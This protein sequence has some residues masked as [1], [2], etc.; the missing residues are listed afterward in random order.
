VTPWVTRRGGA[1]L[2]VVLWKLFVFLSMSA[3]T[4]GLLLKTPSCSCWLEEVGTLWSMNE[5]TRLAES[6]SKLCDS[7]D[8]GSLDRNSVS[9]MI[10]MRMFLGTASSRVSEA[11]TNS[12]NAL[13]AAQTAGED[14]SLP[15]CLFFSTAL[16]IETVNMQYIAGLCFVWMSG[17][18]AIMM[19]TL[20]I[21][22]D[23]VKIL[24][25]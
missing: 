16:T 9:C 17:K 25:M 13:T 2:G 19:T 14:R 22:W 6:S 18:L 10:A 8:P 3:A 4:A 20:V 24:S 7:P 1:G 5:V 11:S 12:D 23:M 15:D 21:F